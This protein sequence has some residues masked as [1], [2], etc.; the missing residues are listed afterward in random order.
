MYEEQL[1]AQLHE[2]CREPHCCQAEVVHS[3]LSH[4]KTI[5]IMSEEIR[6][7]MA[8]FQF[9]LQQSLQVET[10]LH[11]SGTQCLQCSLQSHELAHFQTLTGFS[12]S[13][14]SFAN[15]TFQSLADSTHCKYHKLTSLK[16]RYVPRYYS[17]ENSSYTLL[18]HT[19]THTH[20]HTP[21]NRK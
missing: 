6:N 4:S 18:I 14:L 8:I 15:S 9:T 21:Q 2:S 3:D 10:R 12:L 13:Q 19:H 7:L 20:T 1:Q 17:K 5:P 16:D 11:F